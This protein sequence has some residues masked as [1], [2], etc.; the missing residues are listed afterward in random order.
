MGFGSFFGLGF[1]LV[2]G[3]DGGKG[4]WPTG[5]EPVLRLAVCLG[6][7]GAGEE[8]LAGAGL[9]PMGKLAVLR[10]AVWIGRVPSPGLD[11]LWAFVAL[12]FPS[13]FFAFLAGGG[14]SAHCPFAVTS[15][16]DPK[17]MLMLMLLAA[18]DALRF[19]PVV[20]PAAAVAIVPA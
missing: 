7:D 10:R 1:G 13:E 3:L 17:L 9:W 4:R 12:A 11:W 19:F 6:R 15:P 20:L 16:C 8:A 14:F 2:G 5:K 18:S